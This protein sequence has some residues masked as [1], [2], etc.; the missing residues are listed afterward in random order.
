MAETVVLDTA[1]NNITC[2]R[3]ATV[4]GA[5]RKSRLLPAP[6]RESYHTTE[7][8]GLVMEDVF[9]GSFYSYLTS[10]LMVKST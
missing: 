4:F 1:V 10:Q 2:L 3:S 7:A 8:Y 6:Q 5:W 9:L